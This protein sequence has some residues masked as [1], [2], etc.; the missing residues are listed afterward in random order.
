MSELNA[1]PVTFKCKICGGDVVNNFLL[2]SCVCSHCGNKWNLEDVIPDYIQYSN[3]ISDINEAYEAVSNNPTVV[4]LERAKSLLDFAADESEKLDG[5]IASDLAKMSRDEIAKI[6][7]LQSYMKGVAFFEKK[8]YQS[9]LAEFEKVPGYK[10]SDEFKKQCRVYVDKQNKTNRFMEVFLG[11][12]FPAMLCIVLKITMDVSLTVL[13]PLFLGLSVVLGLLIY[14]GG[15]TG[16][17]V[18]LVSVLSTIPF[19]VFLI[20][21][22]DIHILFFKLCKLIFMYIIDMIK[23]VLVDSKK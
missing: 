21:R 5:V 3:I 9:A 19:L 1:T 8:N 20:I 16:S 4:S 18:K 22:Y 23:Y 12:L 11:M 14:L 17:I 6:D 15:L 13:I 10:N 2:G 7:K